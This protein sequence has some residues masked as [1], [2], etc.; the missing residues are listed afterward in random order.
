[1]TIKKLNLLIDYPVKW[2]EYAVIENFI[3][4]FYD[5]IGL[6]NFANDFHTSYSDQIITMKSNTVFDKEWLYYMG[7]STKRSGHKHY[8]GHFGEGFKIAALVA[9]RDMGL[10]IRME[11]KDWVLTVSECDQKIGEEVHKTLAYKVG[12]RP[13]ESNS[14]LTLEGASE[15]L[16]EIVEH[17]KLDFFYYENPRFGEVI[18]CGDNYAVINA[19]KLESK[20]CRGGLFINLQCRQILHFP[21]FFCIHSYAIERDDRDRIGLANKEIQEAICAAIAKIEADEA[22]EVLEIFKSI[23]WDYHDRTWR[24]RNWFPV[25]YALVCKIEDDTESKKRFTKKYQNELVAQTYWLYASKWKRVRAYEWLKQSEF[26]NRRR[27]GDIFSSL[28]I[29]DVCSLCEENGGFDLDADPNRNEK[30]KIKILEKVAAT[31]FSDIICYD[32]LPECRI[33]IN[34]QSP[35]LGEARCMREDRRLSNAKGMRVQ[36]RISTVYL[37]KTVLDEKCLIDALPIYLHELLHQFGG[38]TSICF[39]RALLE[40][41]R[42][43]LE[44]CGD[45]V[46]YEEKWKAIC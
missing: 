27:V 35:A 45:I 3:Q 2:S 11:S 16:Y 36:F 41:N 19:R 13:Y 39:H 44:C 12:S 20:K 22:I 29:Q 15:K 7:T 21:V 24:R 14:I 6:E 5:A 4:N 31:F 8:A 1:M 40:M 33:L 43:F 34:K 18:S 42:R 30:K 9:Y 46:K 17:K 32:S 38:D 37:L 26:C 25:L 23:W 10:S 28:G